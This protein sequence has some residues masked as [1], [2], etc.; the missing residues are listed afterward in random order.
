MNSNEKK[1][2]QYFDGQGP[3]SAV[4]SSPDASAYLA[5]LQYL[6][7]GVRAIAQAPGIS[8]AQFSSFMDGIREGIDTPTRGQWF[9]GKLSLAGAA[10][11]VA[12][13]VFVILESKNVIQPPVINADECVVESTSS[14]IRDVTV[15]SETPDGNAVVWM[16]PSQVDLW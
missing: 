8:D 10:L 6:R 15:K 1:V 5:D 4:P 16:T 2:A 7:G 12:M 9:W 14:D 3:E 11:V 13:A